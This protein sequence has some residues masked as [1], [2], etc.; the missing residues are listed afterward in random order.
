[1]FLYALVEG[2]NAHPWN[3]AIIISVIT[4]RFILKYSIFLIFFIFLFL[5]LRCFGDSGN[6]FRLMVV[7]SY[8]GCDSSNSS[9]EKQK[10]H[11]RLPRELFRLDE[12]NVSFSLICNRVSSELIFPIG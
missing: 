1:M 10:Y 5:V 7:V 9:V 12:S 3:S 4:A 2:G 8:H 11:R 6:S